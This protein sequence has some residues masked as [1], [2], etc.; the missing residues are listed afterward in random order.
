MTIEDGEPGGRFG[1]F[2]LTTRGSFANAGNP[3]TRYGRW[4]WP[5]GRFERSQS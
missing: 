5:R 1:R 3:I 2:N 4:S